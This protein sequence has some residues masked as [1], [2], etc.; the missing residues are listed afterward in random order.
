MFGQLNSE[1]LQQLVDDLKSIHAKPCGKAHENP[2]LDIDSFDCPMQKRNACCGHAYTTYAETHDLLKRGLV[3]VAQMRLMAPS[4]ASRHEWA[5]DSNR[6]AFI[7][8]DLLAAGFYEVDQLGVDRHIKISTST[9]DAFAAGTG[10]LAL[11]KETE[12]QLAQERLDLRDKLVELLE[13]AL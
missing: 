13:G 7:S 11:I 4:E 1:V 2:K 8:L 5:L 3:S 10:S 9:Y 12:L 6:R